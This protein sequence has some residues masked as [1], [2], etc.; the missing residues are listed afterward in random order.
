VR[1]QAGHSTLLCLQSTC[2]CLLS[3]QLWTR[4]GSVHCCMDRYDQTHLLSKCHNVGHMR[5]MVF[6]HNMAQC[7]STAM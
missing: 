5:V 4:E 3:V 6:S 1:A 2:M 7:G